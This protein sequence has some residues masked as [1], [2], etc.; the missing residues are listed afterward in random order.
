M[1]EVNGYS[2]QCA[3]EYQVGP[4]NKLSKVPQRC[5]NP[6]PLSYQGNDCEVDLNLCRSG[7]CMNGGT[8]TNSLNTYSCACLPSFTNLDCSTELDACVSSPCVNGA[9]VVSLRMTT[10]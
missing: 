8:C 3:S 9:C 5:F 6:S 7:P 2:C 10:E 1:D 4:L